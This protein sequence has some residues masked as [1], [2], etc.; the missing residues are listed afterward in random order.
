LA[1]FGPYIISDITSPNIICATESNYGTLYALRIERNY[2]GNNEYLKELS[3]TTY[4]KIVGKGLINQICTDK[5]GQNQEVIYCPSE[6]TD[7]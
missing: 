4:D 3:D 2:E 1:G 5:N 6:D 7:C